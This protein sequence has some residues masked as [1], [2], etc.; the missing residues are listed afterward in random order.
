MTYDPSYKRTLRIILKPYGAIYI[1]LLESKLNRA[2]WQGS[3]KGRF[4]M[5]ILKTIAVTLSLVAMAVAYV[6]FAKADEVNWATKVTIDEPMEVGDLLLSPGTYVFKLEDAWLN[7]AVEI[8]SADKNEYLGMVIGTPA[9]R[10]QTTSDASLLIKPG[11]PARLDTWYYPNFHTGV[12]FIYPGTNKAAVKGA[13][14]NATK[15]HVKG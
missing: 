13:Q 10:P 15:A 2:C 7:D 12:E 3:W 8:Y 9:Y 6:P 4:D 14:N 11:T 5:R 1:K